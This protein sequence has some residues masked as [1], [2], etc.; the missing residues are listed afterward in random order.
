[1][2]HCTQTFTGEVLK[3]PLEFTWPMLISKI[4]MRLLVETEYNLVSCVTGR[5]IKW[6]E[7]LPLFIL[8]SLIS[9]QSLLNSGSNSAAMMACAVSFRVQALCLIILSV[10]KSW[11]KFILDKNG[12]KLTWN[13]LKSKRYKHLN[14]KPMFR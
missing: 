5:W 3:Y 7:N 9:S 12:I 2:H 4:N 6:T 10:K 1:M 11:H 14:Y 13:A 8:A